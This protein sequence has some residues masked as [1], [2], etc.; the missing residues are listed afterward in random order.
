M[1]P[2][3]PTI[4]VVIP[5]YGEP[6]PTRALV[7]QVT[8]QH[9][10]QVIVSDDCSP[11]PLPPTDGALVVRRDTNGGFGAAVNSGAALATGD[12]LLVLNSDLEI[13]AGFI[14]ALVSAATPW[15][16]AV[17]GPR[18]LDHAGTVTYSGRRWPT[19]LNQSVEW[20]TPLTRWRE[21]PWLRRFLG[22]DT[23]VP[24]SQ[25]PVVVDWL[26]GAAFM[27]PTKAFRAIGGFDERFYMNSE[28][29][30][31]QRRLAALGLRRVYVPSVAVTHEGG[32]SSDPAKR[33]R[34]LVSAQLRYARKWGGAKRLQAAL[35]VATVVNFLWNLTRRIRGLA[36]APVTTAREE[37]GL[38]WRAT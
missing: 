8:A 27:L 2:T 12:L 30:D 38:I 9:P 33:R 16:P 7:A 22:H 26:V 19:I 29:V 5:H 11:T 13:P 31:L 32:G 10:H 15:Q 37:L 36:V 1:M 20:L 3:S 6:A 4:S 23:R 28:E 18:V 34:W 25:T 35:T 14:E 21:R 24:T 17:V